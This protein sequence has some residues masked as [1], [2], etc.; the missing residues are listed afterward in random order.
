VSEPQRSILHGQLATIPSCLPPVLFRNFSS[1][2]GLRLQI[3]KWVYKKDGDRLFNRACSHRTRGNGFEPKKG[4]FRLGIRKKFFIMRVANPWH[5]LP[6][7]M[8]VA[9]SLEILKVRLDGALS[10]LM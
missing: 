3:L 5:K 8:V 10:N 2:E 1:Y 4:R 6:R 9:P 7:E